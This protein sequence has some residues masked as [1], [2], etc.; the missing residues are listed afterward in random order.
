MNYSELINQIVGF[1]GLG[2]AIWQAIENHKLKKYI[3]DESMET[4]TSSDNLRSCV[5]TSLN[6]LLSGNI[7]LGIQEAG[8]VEGLAHALFTKSIKSI[9]SNFNYTKSDIEVWVKNNKI[10][11]SHKDD[12]LRYAEK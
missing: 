7:N 9:H 1:V 11:A 2:L 5:Q 10:H 12:F 6:A 8:K 3:K 4:Y